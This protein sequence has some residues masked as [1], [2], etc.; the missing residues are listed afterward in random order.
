MRQY[1]DEQAWSSPTK[2]LHLSAIRHFFD[3]A[4]MR[5]A[6]LI[7][8]AKSVRGERHRAVEGK[9]PETSIDQARRLLAS[10]SDATR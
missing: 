5:H 8:P 7:N 10:I 2:N 3:L 9:T 6:V 4:V 1:L